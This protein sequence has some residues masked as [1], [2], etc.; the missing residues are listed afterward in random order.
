MGFL[1]L[2]FCLFGMG[3]GGLLLGGGGGGGGGLLCFVVVIF[4]FV[5]SC[6][7]LLQLTLN[8]FLFKPNT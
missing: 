6:F 1:F 5:V 2:L 8:K 3:G 7:D 4:V